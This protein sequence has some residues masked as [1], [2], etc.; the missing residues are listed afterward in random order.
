[1]FLRN[2]HYDVGQKAELQDAQSQNKAKQP[3]TGF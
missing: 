3:Q 1:M 2:L